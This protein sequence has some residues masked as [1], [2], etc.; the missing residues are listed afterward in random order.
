VMLTSDVC[1]YGEASMY[2]YFSVIYF[3]GQF[4]LQQSLSVF[5]LSDFN[6][7]FQIVDMFVSADL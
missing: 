5:N 2:N 4:P 6:S 1:L 7:V 3:S